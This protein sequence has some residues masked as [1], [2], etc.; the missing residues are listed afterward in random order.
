MAI[1]GFAGCLQAIYYAVAS[2][3]IFWLWYYYFLALLMVVIIARIVVSGCTLWERKGCA[4]AAGALAVILL[5]VAHN[6][7]FIDPRNASVAVTEPTTPIAEDELLNSGYVFTFN[8]ISFLM[9]RDFFHGKLP[10]IYRIAMGDRSGGVLYWGREIVDVLFKPRAS[11]SV[12]H[13][14]TRSEQV[15][16]AN[17]S[18]VIITLVTTSLIGM[19]FRRASVKTEKSST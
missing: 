14:L 1:F 12:I 17:I 9:L 19:R 4:L 8:Q 3:W 13:T 18:R 2:T 7:L 15:V 10:Q 16:R 11:C 5:F 6:V